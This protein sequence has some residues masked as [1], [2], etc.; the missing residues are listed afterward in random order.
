MRDFITYSTNNIDFFFV[1]AQTV[2]RLDA[3]AASYKNYSQDML[4][5]ENEVYWHL[6]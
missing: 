2:K 4:D 5:N 3:F 6:R 1:A